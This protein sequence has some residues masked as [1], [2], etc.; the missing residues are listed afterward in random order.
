MARIL[1]VEDDHDLLSLYKAVLSRPGHTV[2]PAAK[3]AE[4]LSLLDRESF[5][6]VILDLNMPDIPGVHVIERVQGDERLHNL[7]VV[8][9]SAN[10]QYVQA[11]QAMGVAQFLIKPVPMRDLLDTVSRLAM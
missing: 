3:T 7:P 2:S 9:I 5:D 6:L 1:V 8:V 4:A 10:Q 11:V